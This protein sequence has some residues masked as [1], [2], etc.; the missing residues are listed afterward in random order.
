MPGPAD[1]PG[2]GGAEEAA[3]DTVVMDPPPAPV[4]ALHEPIAPPAR[5]AGRAPAR[6]FL[7]ALE[8]GNGD[9]HE[10]SGSRVYV[11]RAPEAGLHIPDTT[12]SRIHAV[13]RLDGEQVVVEDAAS[14]NGVF[15]NGI[16]VRVAALGDF[17]TITFGNVAYLFRLGPAIDGTALRGQ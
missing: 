14:T 3:T 9:A 10:L 5:A 1:E 4:A 2:P 11:G 8:P 17:D 6:R 16:R 12:V 15:V 13:L 7:I